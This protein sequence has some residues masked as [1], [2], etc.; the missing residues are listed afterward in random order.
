MTFNEYCNMGFSIREGDLVELDNGRVKQVFVSQS[1]ENTPGKLHQKYGERL[2][3]D[4]EDLAVCGYTLV[5]DVSNRVIA[6]YRK[7]IHSGGYDKVFDVTSNI[8]DF[9]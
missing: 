5:L 3:I 6:V 8:K 2:A 7:S 1:W 9:N 4:S